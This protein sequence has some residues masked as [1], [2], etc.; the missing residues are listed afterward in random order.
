VRTLAVRRDSTLLKTAVELYLRHRPDAGGW[1]P[2]CERLT[3]SVRECAAMVMRAAGL[4]AALYD[5]PSRRPEATHWSR[6]P[7]ANLPVYRQSND[8]R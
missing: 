6:Q 7:T 3:C 1:C 2:R 8:S 5:S 4:D